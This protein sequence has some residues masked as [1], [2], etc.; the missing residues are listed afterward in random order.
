MYKLVAID[1]DGTMLNSYGEISQKNKETIKENIEKGIQIVI[2]SGRNFD[3][4]KNY[5]Q[6]IEGCRY[7]IAGNGAL[8]Y[9]MQNEE[10]IYDKYIPK[11]KALKIIK[12]CEENSITYSVYT[13]KEIIANSLKHNVL[14]YYKSNLKKEESKKTNIKIVENIYEYI[15]EQDEE[16]MKIFISDDN[17][18]VFN[19]IIRKL[20][21]IEN[22]EVLDVSH[23]SRKIIQNG[24]EE[25]VIE[26]FYTEVAE[27][28]VDK[29]N[30]L[31]FLIKKLNI[32]KN[33]VMAIGDNVN[34]KK[35]IMEAGLGATLKNSEPVVIEV[36]N[37]VTE[38]TN[39][40]DGVAEVLL[41]F[42]KN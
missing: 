13:N 30:A 20:K 10:I 41:K 23:M 42:I 4:A 27:K 24:S 9:D 11:L 16:V 26:Y 3:S 28:D 14:Y 12:L 8:I 5:A 40:E 15:K 32:D 31:E 39:D 1:L 21:E 36:A 19:A 2:A 7:V 18:S 35:M 17:K 25:I 22:I 33:E 29:W 6:E 37:Y 34:D 38:N